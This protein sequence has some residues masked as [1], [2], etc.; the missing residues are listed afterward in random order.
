[1]SSRTTGIRAKPVF[2]RAI[3]PLKLSPKLS[4]RLAIAPIDVRGSVV[5]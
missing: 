5:A 1:M 3:V 4:L 2:V